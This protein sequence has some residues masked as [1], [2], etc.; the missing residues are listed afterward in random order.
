MAHILR[1]WGLTWDSYF[2]ALGPG[3]GSII[4]LRCPQ[5]TE[6]PKCATAKPPS[7][8]PS[9]LPSSSH[10][11]LRRKTFPCTRLNREKA[12]T[13][14]AEIQMRFSLSLLGSSLQ[15]TIVLDLTGSPEGPG[16]SEN[17][18]Q[19]GR[20]GPS[21]RGRWFIDT[22]KRLIYR[23]SWGGKD[24]ACILELMFNYIWHS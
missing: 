23:W 17:R 7:P 24:A 6:Q 2:P 9:R 8:V 22:Q 19:N 4:I 3:K 20:R 16:K 21:V 15:V 12:N 1:L 5:R 14:A 11:V 10:T 18:S 13:H